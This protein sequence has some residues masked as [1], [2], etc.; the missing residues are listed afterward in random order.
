MFQA[1]MLIREARLNE[2]A[3]RMRQLE[4]IL[5]F[6]AWDAY[7]ASERAFRIIEGEYADD[8]KGEKAAQNEKLNK[9]AGGAFG[10]IER[11]ESAKKAALNFLMEGDGLELL[12]KAFSDNP[13]LHHEILESLRE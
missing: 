5:P 10:A 7:D 6:W 2:R 3:E 9:P 4:E 11:A 12:E 13:N 8:P 1:A